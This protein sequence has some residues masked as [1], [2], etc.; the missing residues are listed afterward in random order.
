MKGWLERWRGRR[1]PEV[2]GGLAI[3]ALFLALGAWTW[4]SW[5]PL[6]M[7]RENAFLM[8]AARSDED[9]E[10]V[11]PWG[12]PV[13]VLSRR[14]ACCGEEPVV[15][16]SGPNGRS[17]SWVSQ[18]WLENVGGDDLFRDSSSL[19]LR[20]PSS[21]AFR[22]GSVFLAW[23]GLLTAWWLLCTLVLAPAPDKALGGVLHVGLMTLGAL[24][25]TAAGEELVGREVIYSLNRLDLG[26][27]DLVHPSLYLV[28]FV[29]AAVVAAWRTLAFRRVSD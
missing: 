1:S 27:A 13:E 20:T 2:S 24:G 25:L 19:N 21:F 11:D 17:E 7:S 16:S 3:L 29:G 9:P 28:P 18:G 15:L 6:L 23:A 8:G 4:E 5:T 12:R 22:F 26:E 10:R 14:V